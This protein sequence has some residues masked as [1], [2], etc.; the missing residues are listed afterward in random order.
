LTPQD[1]SQQEETGRRGCSKLE[2]G[3]KAK[4]VLLSDHQKIKKIQ[5]DKI[6]SFGFSLKF[7]V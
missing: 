3:P 4:N 5:K 6:L 1:P 7:E 2:N